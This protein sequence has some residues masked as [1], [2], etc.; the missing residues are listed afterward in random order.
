MSSRLQRPLSG[1]TWPK[2]K[3]IEKSWDFEITHDVLFP[4]ACCAC[5]HPDRPTCLESLLCFK[6]EINSPGN[7]WPQNIKVERKTSQKL[8][9]GRLHSLS[10]PKD[11]CHLLEGVYLTEVVSVRI[12]AAV[13]L[14]KCSFFSFPLSCL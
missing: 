12:T 2:E 10:S 1:V 8:T 13:T 7:L 9:E 5:T 6:H 11:L 4:L 3:S 14:E